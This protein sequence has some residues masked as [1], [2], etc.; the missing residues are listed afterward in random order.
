MEGIGSWEGT[1]PASPI[2]FAP[3]GG[4]VSQISG[5]SQLTIGGQPNRMW[6]DS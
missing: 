2:P 1:F 5:T 4:H 6:I 3:G